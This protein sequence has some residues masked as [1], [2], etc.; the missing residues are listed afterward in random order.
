MA[1][2][3]LND[4]FDGLQERK[5]D[6]E[7]ENKERAT[8]NLKPFPD[9]RA[10]IAEALYAYDEGL[11]LKEKVLQDQ[12]FVA[13]LARARDENADPADREALTNHPAYDRFQ[14]AI[15]RFNVADVNPLWDS[16]QKATAAF[17]PR[18]LQFALKLTW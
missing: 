13:A 2:E 12:S 9:E 17:D 11:D 7:K 15:N 18:Q 4:F 16:G 1:L 8:K 14:A 3:R 5:A 6:R 10:E